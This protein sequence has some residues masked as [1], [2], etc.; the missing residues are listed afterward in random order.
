MNNII[1]DNKIFK[2]FDEMY[3]VSEYGEVYSTYCNRILKQSI[4]TNGY[5]RVDIHGRHFTIH[6]LVYL[7]WIGDISEGLQINHKDDNRFNNHYT[8]LYAGTQKENID[9]CIKNKHRVG[10]L[11][12]LTIYDRKTG[13]TITF[14]PASDFIEYSGHPSSSGS[15][16]KMLNKKWVKKGYE[17]VNYGIGKV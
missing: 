17:I 16:K 1:I 12:H 14:C 8:N 5:L 10:N 11:N 7:T 13:E 2:P 4:G 3:Y 9:D 15:I 6:K